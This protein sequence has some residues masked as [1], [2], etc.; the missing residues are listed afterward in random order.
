MSCWNYFEAF[1]QN[2][3]I[4]I[5]LSNHWLS[6]CQLVPSLGTS[7]FFINHAFQQFSDFTE[8]T[9][10]GKQILLKPKRPLML[11]QPTEE[12]ENNSEKLFAIKISR[13][14]TIIQSKCYFSHRNYF[15]LPADSTRWYN[16]F[17]LPAIF[18]F[19]D[20]AFSLTKHF[21]T[22]LCFLFIFLRQ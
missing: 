19:S 15:H 14:V 22:S 13:K 16:D 20:V 17:S 8:C 3:K 5:F 18:C 21:S 12:K 10:C 2:L 9:S 7:T 4:W 11:G 1:M 6:E